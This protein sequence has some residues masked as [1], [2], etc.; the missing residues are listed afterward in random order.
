ML[1]LACLNIWISDSEKLDGEMMLLACLGLDGEKCGVRWGND[2]A[3]Q[4]GQFYD[5]LQLPPLS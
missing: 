2:A 1:L 5:G 3:G 4:S